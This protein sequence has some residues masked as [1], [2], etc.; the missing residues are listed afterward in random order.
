M[1]YH[2]IFSTKNYYFLT[3]TNFLVL[4]NIAAENICVFFTSHFDL[5]FLAP[6]IF[7]VLKYIYNFG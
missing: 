6:I 3:T 5:S 1:V 4:K 7:V 2:G